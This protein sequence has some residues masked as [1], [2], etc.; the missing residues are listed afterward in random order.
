MPHEVSGSPSDQTA[1]QPRANGT[2]A[3]G[4]IRDRATPSSSTATPATVSRLSSGARS[5]P[6]TKRYACKLP[7][8]SRNAFGPHPASSIR[9][10]AVHGA[11]VPSQET[12]RYLPC[13]GAIHISLCL[14]G[15][16]GPTPST[17]ARRASEL[18]RARSTSGTPSRP[19]CRVPSASGLGGNYQRMAASWVPGRPAS[20]SHGSD[21]EA[22]QGADVM[23]CGNFLY[24]R[25]LGQ[26]GPET[27][28]PPN[29]HPRRARSW[30]RTSERA[31]SPLPST[32]ES[33][34]HAVRR[35][36]RSWEKVRVTFR[37]CCGNAPR[38]PQSTAST[39]PTWPCAVGTVIVRPR[40]GVAAHGEEK[41][42]VLGL[43]LDEKDLEVMTDVS[44]GAREGARG[45]GFVREARRLWA[46]I[47][48]HALTGD[49]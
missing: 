19:P 21:A 7:L 6:L 43:D 46:R 44:L 30:F 12:R 16:A 45:K 27:P 15:Y 41:R 14:W 23:P 22:G 24:T 10:G 47:R 4:E 33:H 36:D 34:P 37:R 40:L 3:E 1:L 26:P 29:S 31:A 38:W 25:Q 28:K 13:P 17:R 48:G 8:T 9:R 20:H 11:P 35:F 18:C 2:P 42:H 5:S 32:Y 39:S 49:M